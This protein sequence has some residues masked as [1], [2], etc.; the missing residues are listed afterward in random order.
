MLEHDGM[1]AMLPY[2]RQ[3]IDEDDVAAVADV[4]RGDWLTT[5]PAVDAFEAR[6]RRLDRRRP[7]SSPSP[8]ARRRCT[9]RTPRPGWGRAT[10]WSPRR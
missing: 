7:L 1:S 6:P 4:L 10:R 3:S 9:W 5:G 2:G 8:T